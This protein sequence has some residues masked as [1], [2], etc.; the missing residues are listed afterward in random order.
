M[1]VGAPRS[2]ERVQDLLEP[3]LHSAVSGPTAVLGAEPQDLHS[4]GA[5]S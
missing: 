3:E 1:G 5:I 4:Q 2:P